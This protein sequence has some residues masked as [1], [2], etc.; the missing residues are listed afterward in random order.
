MSDQLR[1]QKE[2]VGK[3]DDS[4]LQMSRETE[5]R[6]IREF[7]SPFPDTE[8]ERRSDSFLLKNACWSR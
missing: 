8:T 7:R 4:R 6:V 3:A 5:Q 2:V 1:P